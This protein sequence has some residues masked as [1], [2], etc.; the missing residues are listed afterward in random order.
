MI[1]EITSCQSFPPLGTAHFS[2]FLLEQ[3]S[4]KHPQ[5]KPQMTTTAK[6]FTKLTLGGKKHPIQLNHRVVLAPLTRVRSGDLGVPTEVVTDYYSQRA[7]DGGLLIT[8]ATNISATARGYYGA[9]GLFR[10]D[11]LKGWEAVTKAVHAKGGKIFAQLW[12]TGRVGHPLNQPNGQLPVSSS[13]TNM[14]DVKSHAITREGRKDYVT[15]RALDISEIPGIIADYK[16]AAENA[17]AVGFDGVEIHAANGYLLE[18]FLCDGVNKRTDAY[19]GR[20]ENRARIIFEV[21]EAV[22]SSVP[23]SQVGIRLS[24]FGDTFGCKDSTPRET[25]SYVVKKLNDY[26]LAYLHVIERRGRHA[27]SVDAPEGG[28]A[29]HFRDIYSGVIISAAGFDR[30]DAIETVEEGSADLVAFGRYFI[31]N[32]DL[33][34]RLRD[35]AELTPFDSGTFYLQPDMPVQAGYTDYPFMGEVDSGIRSAGYAKEL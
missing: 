33:V 30:A 34:E 13:A 18:E 4:A 8:E 14:E 11:Q 2:S 31:S 10:Q 25:Y 21:V 27:D 12:H 16:T 26:D 24:P 32:P 29:R 3:T 9:P 19:G 15:P 23:S 28:V 1:H 35:N 17:I 20:I 7:T 5:I 6:L 22:L